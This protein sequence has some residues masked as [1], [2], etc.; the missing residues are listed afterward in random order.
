MLPVFFLLK[1]EVSFFFFWF[2]PPPSFFPSFWFQQNCNL[3][4]KQLD[5]VK[6]QVS[7]V[8]GFGKCGSQK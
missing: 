4:E 2:F 7:V 5:F 3:E 1:S 6:S 8:F